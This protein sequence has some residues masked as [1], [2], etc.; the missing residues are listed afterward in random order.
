LGVRRTPE[1]K[2]PGN[3]EAETYWLGFEHVKINVYNKTGFEKLNP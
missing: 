2:V 3:E 1:V